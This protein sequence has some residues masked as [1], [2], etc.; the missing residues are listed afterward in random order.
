MSDERNLGTKARGSQWDAA[1]LQKQTRG[2]LEYDKIWEMLSAA[3]VQKW[4]MLLAA[5]VQ[6]HLTIPQSLSQLK[7][8]RFKGKKHGHQEMWIEFSL[9]RYEDVATG[10]VT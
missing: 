3:G 5:G 4:E 7:T 9:Q 6:N 10:I 8:I 2:C 1:S